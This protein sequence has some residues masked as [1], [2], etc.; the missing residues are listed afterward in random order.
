[1]NRHIIEVI[2]QGYDRLSGVLRDAS[3]KAGPA[4]D[5]LNNKFRTNRNEAE[6]AS[7]A[8]RDFTDDVDRSA[9]RMERARNSIDK[10]NTS[11][12]RLRQNVSRKIFGETFTET[13][14]E[15]YARLGREGQSPR[16]GGRF[17]SRAD[18]VAQ[19]NAR[20]AELQRNT[21]FQGRSPFDDVL[22]GFQ[23]GAGFSQTKGQKDI[24]ALLRIQAEERL[25]A[26][27]TERQADRR[28]LEESFQDE[29][30]ASERKIA[31]VRDEAQK[32]IAAAENAYRKIERDADL[33][34]QKDKIRIRETVNEEVSALRSKARYSGKNEERLAE[35]QAARD[36]ILNLREAAQEDITLAQKRKD[37]KVAAAKETFRVAANGERDLIAQTD[38][39]E[40][41][42]INRSISKRR[43]EFDQITAEG[44]RAI[45]EAAVNA[46]KD[47][48]GVIRDFNRVREDAIKDLPII[49]RG[50]AR[51]GAAFSDFRRGVI[52]GKNG[53]EEFK[54]EALKAQSAVGQ[55]GAAFGAARRD[56]NSFINVR[57]VAILSIIQ[58]LGPLIVQ[59]GGALIALGSSAVVAAAGIG[60]A[61]LAGIAE[62][63]P[64]VGLVVAAFRDL[65]GAMKVVQERQQARESA[66]QSAQASENARR[67]AV[68]QLAD[69]HY[70]LGQAIYSVGQAERGLR[71]A[72]QQVTD[73]ERAQ[74]EAVQ[75]L[76]DARQ[77]AARNIV[78]AAFAEK[79]AELSLQE[80]VL[81]VLDAKQRLADFEKKQ[82]ESKAALS[83]AQ[84]ALQEA[85]QRL[86]LA[87]QQGDAI[88][89]AQA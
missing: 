32:R 72:H 78:D 59:L 36:E 85:E 10:M 18:F 77:Q 11:F 89:I 63:I 73:A 49:E 30:T 3:N 53:L 82:S 83:D 45:R 62:A 29:K 56:I 54:G 74:R 84:A 57:W 34:L 76:A 28:R 23:T 26:Y 38:R 47:L 60:G 12:S 46:E 48:P 81:G 86:A 13:P 43:K 6:K 7:G 40:T 66:A 39:E 79:D 61:F 69:A 67:S 2:V 80:A 21:L 25:A 27:N 35:A 71:D 22:R 1:M 31:V 87:K 33:A 16:A 51:A 70:Q 19:E 42:S 88:E 50:A 17:Q 52:G 65:Q 75:G 55:M 68:Q 41:A 9:V 15:M 4:L 58:T 44:R 24:K 20:R 8:V 64:A 5:N 14:E 37:A